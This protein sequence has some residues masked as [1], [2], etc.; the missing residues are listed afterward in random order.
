MRLA[1]IVSPR[2]VAAV[3]SYNEALVLKENLETTRAAGAAWEAVLPSA[4]YERLRAGLT[5]SNVVRRADGVHVRLV[6]RERPLPG[7][8]PVEP[9]LEDA[10]LHL[11]RSLAAVAAA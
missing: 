9:D 11:M 6:G 4:E 3:A 7:A 1:R 5:V 8:S 10:Y 2:V